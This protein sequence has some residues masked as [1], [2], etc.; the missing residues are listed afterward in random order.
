MKHIACAGNGIFYAVDSNSKLRWYRHDKQYEGVW[1][2]SKEVRS[3]THTRWT[4]GWSPFWWE[5]GGVAFHASHA[6]PK[7]SQTVW[8]YYLHAHDS[9]AFTGDAEQPA[10]GSRFTLQLVEW[11]GPRQAKVRIRTRLDRYLIANAGGGVMANST[12]PGPWET[13]IIEGE[14]VEKPGEE[15]GFRSWEGKLLKQDFIHNEDPVLEMPFRSTPGI[16][17]ADYDGAYLKST[18]FGHALSWTAHRH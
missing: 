9:G 13:W 17:R 14:G 15:L 7:A 3:P 11:L 8:A 4:G 5:S 2:W 10:P 1:G 6:H 12:N 18:L 16:P